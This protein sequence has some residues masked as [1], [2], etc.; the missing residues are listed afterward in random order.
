MKKS[1]LIFVS[2]FIVIFDVHSADKLKNDAP[3]NNTPPQNN[4]APQQINIVNIKDQVAKLA[5][6]TMNA[7]RIAEV[8]L[9]KY[10]DNLKDSIPQRD[11]N[12]TPQEKAPQKNIP[13]EKNPQEKAP[14]EI[15]LVTASKNQIQQSGIL[16][17]D[18]IN[19]AKNAGIIAIKYIAI[20]YVFSLIYQVLGGIILYAGSLYGSPVKK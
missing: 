5:G 10:P 6:V 3:Q 13:Q 9:S 8:S 19:E 7:K 17:V 12:I 4:K 1:Y 2:S 18:W 15:N 16:Q 20:V 14:Q 11:E